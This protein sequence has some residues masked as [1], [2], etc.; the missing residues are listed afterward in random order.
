MLHNRV[1]TPWVLSLKLFV[2]KICF[3]IEL[4]HQSWYLGNDCSRHMMGEKHMLHIFL[5]LKPQIFFHHN[6]LIYWLCAT[7][8]NHND[9]CLRV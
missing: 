2:F 6:Y 1:K 4:K 8:F 3:T 7:L 5:S 9:A